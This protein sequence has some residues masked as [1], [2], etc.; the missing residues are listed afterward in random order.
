MTHCPAPP[1]KQGWHSECVPAGGVGP[2]LGVSPGALLQQWACGAVGG[3]AEQERAVAQG[4]RGADWALVEGE[5]PGSPG[6]PHPGAKS[7]PQEA[8]GCH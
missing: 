3:Q 5:D 6:T 2:A 8:A 7:L 1:Q 4:L